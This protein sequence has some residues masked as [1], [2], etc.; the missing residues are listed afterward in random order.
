[1][2]RVGFVMTN[3]NNA[4]YTRGAVE[5]LA[6]SPDWAECDVAIVDNNSTPEDV[7]ALRRLQQEHPRVHLVLN[8]SNLGYFR[9]LNVGLRYLREREPALNLIVVGNNDLVFPP[10]FVSALWANAALLER[11]W[12]IAPD[13]ITLDGVHQNPHVLN[14]ISKPRQ[15]VYDLYFASYPLALSIRWIARITRRF[16]SRTDTGAHRIAGPIYMGYGACYI[17]G[18]QFFRNFSELWAP[19]FLMGEEYFLSKQL[20]DRGQQ[21]YYEP[22]IR[23]QHYDHASI[24]KL[25]SRQMWLVARESHRV[26]RRY[27]RLLPTVTPRFFRPFRS[28]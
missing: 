12:V 10:D 21:V 7:D 8:E 2:T 15:A 22:S 3:Y 27:E 23:V 18:P 26:Y 20:G 16:T 13:L 14:A 28:K 5:S 25:P 17:L 9:G 1:M 24:D 6:K 19:V 4:S 11:H